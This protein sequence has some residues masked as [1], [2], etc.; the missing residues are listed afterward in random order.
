MSTT[1][2]SIDGKLSFDIV[3][4]LEKIQI[5]KRQARELGQEHPTIDV[6]AKTGAAEAQLAAVSAAAKIM[7][8]SVE[9]AGERV[10][11]SSAD[12]SVA[13]AKVAAANRA[14]DVAYEKARIAQL[15]LSEAQEA[16]RAKASTMAAAEL[17]A[18]EALERLEK[19]NARATAAEVALKEA[20]QDAANAALKQAAAEEAAA[21]A[22]DN[23]G[24][25]AS[26]ANARTQLIIAAVAGLTVVAG[27]ATAALVG[28][29][30]ALGGMGA[31]GVLG[32]VGAVQ[33]IKQ[34][35][36][37]G[38]EWSDGLHTLKSD[39]SALSAT[40]AAGLLG[41]FQRAV[42][43][44]NASMPELNSEVA[45]F[46]R[47]LGGAALT[48]VQAVITAF[49][50]LNPLF[51]QGAQVIQ[52]IAD[53]FAEW[54]ANGGMQS[55]AAYAAAELPR[56]VGTID[57]LAA[58]IVHVATATAPVGSLV[59]DTLAGIARA[60]NAI[61]IDVLTGLA[62]GATTGLLAF[63]AWAIIAPM[64]DN[65]SWAVRRFGEESTVVAGKAGMVGVSLGVLTTVLSGVAAILGHAKAQQEGY[66]YALEQDNHAIGENVR[67]TALKQL[68][69]SG[70]LYQAKAM[71][72][73][74]RELIDATIG[75]GDAY[76]KVTKTIEEYSHGNK[77]Q[78]QA[79][80]T[81]TN[82]LGEQ[83]DSLKASV[84]AQKEQDAAVSESTS[85]TAAQ[86]AEIKRNADAAGVSVDA[87]RAVDQSQSSMA[88]QIQQAT[89]KM[90]IQ[91]D[92]A[93]L[94]RQALDLLNGKNLTAAEAQNRFESSLASAAKQLDQNGAELDGMSDAAIANRG[95]IIDL[96]KTAE[97]S[98]QAFRDQ[99]GAD[100]EARE[101]MIDSRQSIIEQMVAH[102]MNRDAVDAY[103]KALFQIPDHVPKTKAEVDTS[104]AEAAIAELTRQ[105]RVYIEAVFT[106][107]NAPEDLNGPASGNGRMG[108]FAYGGTI[109]GAADGVTAL[110][111]GSVWG[112]GSAS[113]DTAGVYRLAHGEEVI[114]NIVGQADRWR[115]TLKAMNQNAPAAQVAGQVMRIAGVAAAPVAPAAP[116]QYHF[117]VNVTGTQQEDPQ[118]LAAIIGGE[119]R[120]SMA[121]GKI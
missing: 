54:T 74:T 59:L 69:D 15:R 109:P 43:L 80:R 119:L 38:Q 65:T 106:R 113:S 31:A 67:L 44:I 8:Q 75:Q 63:K 35:T 29:G 61:P 18:S 23:A 87:Y 66:T 100:E 49:H 47:I 52:D 91:G 24:N 11:R 56:V 50:T 116:I 97:D 4:F 45:G 19:A 101:K 117:H 84:A 68:T 26:R 36:E 95:T 13:Q 88:D 17:A 9:T 86:T 14:A 12:V 3:D 34:G 81:L 77:A 57:E 120:R 104:A 107:A 121:G 64:I 51:L 73:Q 42:A 90:Y 99:G 103:V 30:G 39:L 37:A 1:V 5:V 83:R 114:S 98:A 60:I 108:T 16:G 82:L 33:A 110:A 92:A 94:L 27:P 2:G 115:P 41:S 7:G 85:Q 58:A 102:G 93:G 6:D 105:R 22:T 20:Q 46:S 32:I 89:A 79:A 48:S 111:G 21:A 71:G 112:N 28:L 70:A 62:A 10:K 72:I 118:V 55:F 96:I 76:S 40:A 25:A 53:G 78:Q